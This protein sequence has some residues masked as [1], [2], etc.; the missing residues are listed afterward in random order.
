[1][2]PTELAALFNAHPWPSTV[3]FLGV[4]AFAAWVLS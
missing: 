2:T 3:A 4:L 1:M